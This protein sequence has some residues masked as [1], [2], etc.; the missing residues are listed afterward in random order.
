MR[1]C[2]IC[3]KGSRPGRM[4]KRR[5]AAKITGGAGQKIT[6]KTHRRFYPN[7]QRIK[8][9]LNGTVQYALVCSRCIKKGKIEKP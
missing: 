8:V 3:H 6:G 7:L 5:G 9:R 1:Q 4:Y 2:V